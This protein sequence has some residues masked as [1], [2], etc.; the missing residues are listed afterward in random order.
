GR[1]EHLAVRRRPRDQLRLDAGQLRRRRRPGVVDRP[2]LPRRQRRRAALGLR[3]LLHRRADPRA[4][5]LRL[6]AGRLHLSLIFGYNR[7]MR[8]SPGAPDLAASLD[9]AYVACADSHLTLYHAQTQAELAKTALEGTAQIGF[10][11]ND[12]LLAVI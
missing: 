8:L 1:R 7:A 9:G 11:G 5:Q 4:H 10:L 6:R 12:R 3:R 2:D